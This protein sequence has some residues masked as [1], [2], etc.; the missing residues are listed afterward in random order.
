MT[1]TPYHLLEL[2]HGR[3]TGNYQPR[4]LTWFTV[5]RGAVSLVGENEKAVKQIFCLFDMIW[6][7]I[8]VYLFY[9][10]CEIFFSKKMFSIFS[11]VWFIIGLFLFFSL[12]LVGAGTNRRDRRQLSS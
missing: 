12:A 9:R 3:R 2:I 7:I 5:G 4:W 6:L 11:S 10:I 8:S 1:D